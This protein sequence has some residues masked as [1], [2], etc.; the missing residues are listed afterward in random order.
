MKGKSDTNAWKEYSFRFYIQ[1][2]QYFEIKILGFKLLVFL[3]IL[4]NL[5]GAF[6]GFIYY[7]EVIGL[8][9]YSPIL[10]ILI[11]DCPMAAL[12]LL[13]VY[14]QFDNQRFSNFNFFVFIQGIRAAIITYLIILNFGSLDIEVVVIG[15]FLLL[16]QAVAILPLLLNLKY[17]K[18]T[19]VTIGITLFN[20]ISDF[21]GIIGI[22]EPTLAQLPTIQPLFSPFVTIVFGLDI[23]LILVG[24]V[25]ARF[26]SQ[27]N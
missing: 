27:E 8:T 24:L 14:I 21:F 10:W 18:G 22:T 7:F 26:M 9:Q 6:I 23:F 20:D 3:L 11:P 19:L 12:L 5:W 13:G 1:R 15:H 2:L 17:T 25:F 4:G 16:I